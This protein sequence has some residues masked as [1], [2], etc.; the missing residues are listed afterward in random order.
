LC[1]FFFFFSTATFTPPAGV[2]PILHNQFYQD[3]YLIEHSASTVVDNTQDISLS[4][5]SSQKGKVGVITGL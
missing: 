1:F 3:L 2:L 5:I 4:S